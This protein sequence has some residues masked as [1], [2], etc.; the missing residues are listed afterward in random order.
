LLRLPLVSFAS[1]TRSRAHASRSQLWQL[2]R[3]NQVEIGE[4][5]DWAGHSPEQLQQMRN[6]LARLKA[7]GTATTIED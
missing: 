4:V 5:E 6:N 3:R 2:P 1:A 7:E